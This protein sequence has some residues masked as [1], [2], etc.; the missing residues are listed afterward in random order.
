MYVYK[1]GMLFSYFK[2][3]TSFM[4][5]TLCMAVCVYAYMSWEQHEIELGAAFKNF[6]SVEGLWLT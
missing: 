5:F 1:D 6:Y 4:C 3:T 2:M